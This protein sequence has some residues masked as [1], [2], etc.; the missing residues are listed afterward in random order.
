MKKDFIKNLMKNIKVFLKKKKKKKSDNMIVSVTK[1]SRKLKN[2]S[3]LSIE[4]NVIEW[5]KTLYYN[6]KKIFWFRK[7]CFASYLLKCKKFFLLLGLEKF[8]RVSLN[9]RKFRFLKH[10]KFFPGFH[11]RKYKNSFLLRKHKKFFR[12]FRFLKY[13]NFSRGGLKG[14]IAWNIRS[15][16]R[17]SI[18]W[19]IRNFFRAGIFFL[20]L[21]Q[22]V[23]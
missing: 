17:A 5:E 6:Y 12:G 1:I 15:F 21:G 23:H 2:K 20:S 11:F 7:F 3:L 16:S 14:S 8:F 9:I 19:N 18:S 13:K 4:K 10:K 22:K